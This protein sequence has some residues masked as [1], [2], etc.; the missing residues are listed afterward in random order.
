MTFSNELSTAAAERGWRTNTEAGTISGESEKVAFRLTV[1]ADVKLELSANITEKNLKKLGVGIAAEYPGAT[2]EYHGYGII[3]TAPAN[4]WGCEQLFA[5]VKTSVE[6]TVKSI[7]VSHDNSY[8][9][10]TE[11]FYTYLRG[12]AGAFIGA[13]VG[14]IPW[15]IVG[16]GWFG[17]WLGAAVGI[18]SFYGYRICKGA[19]HTKFAASTVIISSIAAMVIATLV[20]TVVEFMMYYEAE[21]LFQAVSWLID[22]FADGRIFQYLGNAGIGIIFG[23]IGMVAIRNKISDYTHE[24]KFLRREKTPRNKK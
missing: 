18:A 6:G 3:I 13:L 14:V 4:L 17:I 8:M 5:F 1:G 15:G 22:M 10:Y 16:G 12:I 9:K 7:S 2:A 23:I 21:N 24:P 11:P 20:R 19:H